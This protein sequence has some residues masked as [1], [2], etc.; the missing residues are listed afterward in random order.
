MGKVLPAARSLAPPS[1]LSVTRTLTGYRPEVGPRRDDEEED[2][3]EH[4]CGRVVDR[5]LFAAD[6]P[7][8]RCAV[9]C[10]SIGAVALEEHIRRRPGKGNDM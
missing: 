3:D 7:V 4:S 8:I 10:R 1:S 2:N 9:L 5:L 6:A